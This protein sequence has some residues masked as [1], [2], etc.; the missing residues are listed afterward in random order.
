MTRNASSQETFQR[1]L[2]VLPA[3][4]ESGQLLH[5]LAIRSCVP[6]TDFVTRSLRA[7]TIIWQ[8]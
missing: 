4:P 6:R 7:C 2:D 8:R 3:G 5:V 1:F